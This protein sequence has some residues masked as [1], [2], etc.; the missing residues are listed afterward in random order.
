MGRRHAREGI[1]RA[2][3]NGQSMGGGIHAPL[4]LRHPPAIAT[5]PCQ[6]R[7]RSLQALGGAAHDGLR[8]RHGLPE[9]DLLGKGIGGFHG[10]WAAAALEARPECL[11]VSETTAAAA[12]CRRAAE[13]PQSVWGSAPG[14]AT[15]ELP[16]PVQALLP[17]FGRGEEAS[18]VN[19][20]DR[21]LL[22]GVNRLDGAYLHRP[23]ADTRAP[24]R[25]REATVVQARNSGEQLNP[26]AT[27]HGRHA[28]GVA[29]DY[30]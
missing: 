8:L 3:A 19:I 20:R 30:P 15:P 1:R 17:R 22:A 16:A 21:Q 25:V 12:R 2:G 9:A 14:A 7:Q 10:Q 28:E 5:C 23:L 4:Q 18:L 27:L 13:G 24:H 26:S 11:P 29:F 6:R